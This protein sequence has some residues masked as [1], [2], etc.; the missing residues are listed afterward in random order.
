MRPSIKHGSKVGGRSFPNLKN[1]SKATVIETAW[2]WFKERHSDQRNVT[3]SRRKHTRLRST[4]V[5]Q[6]HQGHSVGQRLCSTNG[7]GTH[8]YGVWKRFKLHST[9]RFLK[10]KKKTHKAQSNKKLD[11]ARTMISHAKKWCLNSYSLKWWPRC[12]VVDYKTKNKETAQGMCC[13]FWG[14]CYPV[15]KTIAISGQDTR[16]RTWWGWL[17]V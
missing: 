13:S 9:V 14:R 1:A 2:S 12:C 5:P 10:K 6:G 15:K 3:E 17:V 16:T 7:A 11:G 4:D 8:V